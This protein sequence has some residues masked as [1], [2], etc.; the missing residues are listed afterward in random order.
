MNKTSILSSKM[1]VNSRFF[2][3]LK[4]KTDLKEFLLQGLCGY[5]FCAWAE[6][7]VC[8]KT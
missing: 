3:T 4:K 8:P 2:A 1:P 5:S 6:I 7:F